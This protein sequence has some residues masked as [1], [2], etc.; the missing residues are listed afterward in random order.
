MDLIQFDSGSGERIARVVQFVEQQPTPAKP[1]TFDAAAAPG[2]RV[3]RVGT[4]NSAW[5]KD[6]SRTVTLRSGSTV[7]AMNLFADIATAVSVRDCAIAREGT[8]WYLIA[9]EC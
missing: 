8:A 2:R 9:A 1:L 4:F 6:A 7:S 5:P 3:F